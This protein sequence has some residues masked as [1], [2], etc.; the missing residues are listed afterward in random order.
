MAREE[1]RHLDPAWSF[2]DNRLVDMKAMDDLRERL[3]RKASCDIAAGT[4][5]IIAKAIL[6]ACGQAWTLIDV[7]QRVRSERFKDATFQTLFLD[8]EPILEL[9]DVTFDSTPPA[10]AGDN[11]KMSANQN[12]RFLGKAAAAQSIAPAP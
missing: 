6:L 1:D 5:G 4:D 12:Y 7:R 8:G 11:W 2:Y 9:H 10:T 3:F